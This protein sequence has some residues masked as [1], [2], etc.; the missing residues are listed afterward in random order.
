M[1][2]SLE[3]RSRPADAALQP[4]DALVDLL[5]LVDQISPF[6]APVRKE[7]LRFPPLARLQA[8]RVAAARQ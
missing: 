5:D 1:V 4:G 3:S 6:G 7:P 8:A 2:V